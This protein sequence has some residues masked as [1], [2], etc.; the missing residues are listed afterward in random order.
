MSMTSSNSGFTKAQKV[1]HW[2]VA[3]LIALQYLFFDGMGRPFHELMNTGFGTYSAT[4]VIH[5]VIGV[6]VLGLAA[7]R[8]LLRARVGAPEAPETE[9]AIAKHGAKLAHVAIYL[10]LILL[11]ISGSIAWFLQIGSAA[12]LH[13]LLTTLLLIVLAVHVA[14]VL[15]HQFIWKTNIIGRMI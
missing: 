8:L 11:P 9:P 15:V 14:A 12:S 2:A 5:I 3:T 7:W 1:L 6:A 13:E 4:V 10:M